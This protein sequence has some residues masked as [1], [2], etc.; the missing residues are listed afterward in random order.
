[1]KVN[2]FDT[3][4]EVY[5]YLDTRDGS[6]YIRSD[7]KGFEYLET[8]VHEFIHWLIWRL[9]P[10]RFHNLFH[11]LFDVTD[12]ILYGWNIKVAKEYWREYNVT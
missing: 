9:L 5:G 2:R 8:F 1:M 11:M 12:S 4:E 3:N 10:K 6:I 7:M